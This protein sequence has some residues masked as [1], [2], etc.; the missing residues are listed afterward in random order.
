MV[1]NVKL[2]LT[3]IFV[4]IT[5]LSPPASAIYNWEGIPVEPRLLGEI[6]GEVLTFGTYGLEAPP[7]DLSFTLPEKPVFGRVYVGIWGGDPALY[8]LGRDQCEQPA[9]ST[10]SAGR[11]T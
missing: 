7:I 4:L 8:R 9:E 3:L 2:I 5:L 1:Q 10:V 6:Q 11:R